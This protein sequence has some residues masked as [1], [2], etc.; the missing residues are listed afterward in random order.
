M[1]ERLAIAIEEGKKK[2]FAS[3]LEWPGWSRGGTTP[4]GAV[5]AL[6]AY[7]PRFAPVAQLAGLPF[8][9][10]FD[11]DV[12]EETGG[13][14][15]TDWGVP[16]VLTF[17]ADRRPVDAAEAARLAAMV[18]A[19]WATFDKVAAG[20]PA[21]LRKGP[22]GGGR[23]RDKMVDHVDGSDWYY[24]KDMGIRLPEPAS[25]ADVEGMRA[26]MLEALR[27]PSDGSPMGGRRWPARYAARRIAWHALDHAWEMEDR[28]T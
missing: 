26:A 5:E 25:R 14:S 4:E 7:A 9:T 28:A 17:A 20:A 16:S 21:E 15:A 8:G 22:R 23:D 24:A 10:A 12:V 27:Q 19:A 2:V 18:E 11:A 6:L 3:A 13:G 1:G